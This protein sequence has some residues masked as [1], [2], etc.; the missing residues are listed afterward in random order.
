MRDFCITA[1]IYEQKTIA[2]ANWV[3]R[4]IGFCPYVLVFGSQA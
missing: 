1:V 4:A 2:D 3:S